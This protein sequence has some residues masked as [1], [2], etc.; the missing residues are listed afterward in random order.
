MVWL[1]V[2]GIFNVRT[3]VDARCLHTGAVRTPK[4]SALVAVVLLNVLGCR[5][6]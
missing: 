6:T 2:M 3:G 4:E 1:P 5:L